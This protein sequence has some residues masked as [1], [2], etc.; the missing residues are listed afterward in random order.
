MGFLLQS[1]F[2]SPVSQV[3]FGGTRDWAK[4]GLSLSFLSK[5]PSSQWVRDGLVLNIIL[6]VTLLKKVAAGSLR[7]MGAR[8]LKK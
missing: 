1:P 8:H 7:R 2:P 5:V 6:A 4:P 3:S